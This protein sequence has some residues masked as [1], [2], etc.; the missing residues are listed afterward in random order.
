MDMSLA[1]GVSGLLIS[2][3]KTQRR[4]SRCQRVSAGQSIGQSNATGI[5]ITGP[6]LHYDH[7]VNGKRVDPQE[8]FDDC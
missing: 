1:A 3:T 5:R 7:T 6:H 4:V 8:V 2:A